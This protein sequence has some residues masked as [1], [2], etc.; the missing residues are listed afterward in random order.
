MHLSDSLK[1]LFRETA[2]TLK[3]NVS[4]T[5]RHLRVEFR[6]DRRMRSSPAIWLPA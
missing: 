4:S 2:E 3:R 5:L 6:E 1:T